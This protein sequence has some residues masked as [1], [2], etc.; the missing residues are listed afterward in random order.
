MIDVV[1]EREALPKSPPASVSFS[2]W[3]RK[4][5]CMLKD[6]IP[7]SL[8]GLPSHLRPAPP[9]PT[10]PTEPE[11]L[12]PLPP[13]DPEPEPIADAEFTTE[14][15]GFGLYQQYTR[16]PQTDPEDCLILAD[17]VDD[18]TLPKQQQSE[19]AAI[20]TP[21]STTAADFFYPFPNTTVF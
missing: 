2:R 1:P 5:P 6:Y 7:H 4:V 9:K 14:P 19:A 17:L 20:E 21:H 13:S 12:S 10:L 15:N 18:D 11:V 16:K 8:V 3:R